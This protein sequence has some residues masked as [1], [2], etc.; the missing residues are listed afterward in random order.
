MAKV[1]RIQ[2]SNQVPKR[3]SSEQRKG[4]QMKVIPTEAFHV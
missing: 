4:K 2:V 1:P 3:K